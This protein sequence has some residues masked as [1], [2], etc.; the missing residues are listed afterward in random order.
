MRDSS[1]KEAGPGACTCICTKLR[2]SNHQYTTVSTLKERRQVYASA[3]LDAL[4]ED[5]GTSE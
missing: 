5:L 2:D 4:I 3:C 1:F